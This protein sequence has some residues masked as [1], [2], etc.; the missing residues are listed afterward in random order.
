MHGRRSRGSYGALPHGSIG[1]HR[2]SNGHHRDSNCHCRRGSNGHHHRESDCVGRHC[3]SVGLCRGSIDHLPGSIGLPARCR[4]SNDQRGPPPASCPRFD[5]S[6]LI[7]T[8]MEHA[9]P[10]QPPRGQFGWKKYLFFVEKRKEKKRKRKY[11]FLYS[12]HMFI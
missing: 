8:R 2:G 6:P 11:P 5:V 10:S 3:G 9:H 1:H 7:S 12:I 4:G